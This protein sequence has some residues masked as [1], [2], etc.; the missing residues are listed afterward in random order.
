MDERKYKI[1]NVE[2]QSEAEYMSAASDLKKI[3]ALTEKYDISNP[4]QAQKIL[5]S[6]YARPDIFKSPYGKKFIE[7]LESVANPAK[8]E[9]KNDSLPAKETKRQP[10]SSEKKHGKDTKLCKYCKTEIPKGAKICPNCRKKQGGGIFK[11]A[12][13]AIV[14][15]VVLV[16]V[17][18]SGEEESPKKVE[19]TGE[20][21]VSAEKDS[22]TERV[23]DNGEAEEQGDYIFGIGET[24]ELNGVRV[25]MT[26]YSESHGSEYNEPAEGNVFVL[27]EF[28]IENNTDSEL[29]ISSVMSFDAYADDYALEYSIG[30][31]M[32]KEESNQLDGAIAAGKKMNGIVGY[33]APEGWK[34]IE[35]HFTENVWKD[36]KFKFKIEKTDDNGDQE[37]EVLEGETQQDETKLDDKME[38]NQYSYVSD[39]F[40]TYYFMEV[41]NNSDVVV[42]IET[43]VIAKD[44]DGKNVGAESNSEEAIAPGYSVCLFNIFE[45]EN[46]SSYE[47]TYSVREDEYYKP[48]MQDLQYEVSDTGNGVVVTCTNTGKEP[49]EFVEGS[50]V[51]FSG[52]SAVGYESTYF[53]D[54]DDEL[55]PGSTLAKDF[56][57]YGESKY[58]SYKVYFTGRR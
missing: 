50:V 13:I 17:F 42:S 52:D 40:G 28:E 56:E 53:T 14:V 18:G 49:A 46:I 27:V 48:V 23:E 32:E 26:D 34:N 11:K 19:S 54:N 29:A 38:I 6:I 15:L 16:A 1:G 58:D 25:T 20:G 21:K 36:N 5:S 31:L 57:Y 35:I 37:S 41:T 30:A 9:T 22:S 7:K 45:N 33:E 43:N 51:F 44:A 8:Q 4:A 47:Y 2:F 10:E 24:A 55:K 12:L 39:G 3:K